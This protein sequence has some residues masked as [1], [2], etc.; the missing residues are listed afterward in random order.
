MRMALRHAGPAE[1]SAQRSADR[2]YG[3]GARIYLFDE[4]HQI[5]T[6]DPPH[7]R[8]HGQDIEG[9]SQTEPGLRPRRRRSP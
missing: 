6:E 3:K 8:S 5:S 7:K 2:R 4:A 1:P 9:E